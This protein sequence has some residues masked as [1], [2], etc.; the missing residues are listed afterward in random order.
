MPNRWIEHVRAFAAKNKMS[1]MCA[2]SDPNIKKGYIP[3][4]R[5]KQK[6]EKLEMATPSTEPKPKNIVIKPRPTPTPAPKSAGGA[7]ATSDL[8]LPDISKKELVVLIREWL[9]D[10]DISNRKKNTSPATKI[11]I[12]KEPTELFNDFKVMYNS[13]KNNTKP[14][15]NVPSFNPKYYVSASSF[16]PAG[17]IEYINEKLGKQDKWKVG[18]EVILYEKLYIVRKVSPIDIT[19]QEDIP[20]IT[21]STQQGNYLNQRGKYPR[22]FKGKKRTIKKDTTTYDNIDPL[23]PNYKYNHYR[24]IDFG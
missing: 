11:W 20:D 15:D 3:T 12:N 14:P 8:K 1:Y 4:E 6:T 24:S 22:E 7:S 5:K 10:Y 19:I 16:S 2:M 17:L 9:A 18:D 13:F 21:G 23:P